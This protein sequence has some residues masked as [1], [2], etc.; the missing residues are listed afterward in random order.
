MTITDVEAIPV[1]LPTHK[2]VRFANG[3]VH[4]AEHVLVR[5]QTEDGLEGV[6]E[7]SPRLMTYGDT[8]Q[9]VV[10]LIRDA[11]APMWIGEDERFIAARHAQLEH[12]VGN[13]PARAALDVALWDLLGKRAGLPVALLYGGARHRVAV[14]H[15]L[16]LGAPQE[17]AQE[18]S[19]V[20]SSLGVRAF[21]VKV[22]QTPQ[23]DV[24]RTLAVREAVGR[25]AVLYLDAN[26]GW[27]PH[28]RTPGAR[29]ARARGRVD[30][31][32]GGAYPR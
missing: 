22:G 8:A 7:A 31:L 23:L 12:L 4:H 29:R 6:A 20:A 25:D 21:K 19:D 18:A 5:V 26:H 13:R 11:I 9:A 24:Q 30:R 3:E 14:A 28:G 2:P 10:A 27:S 15:L 32:G 1:R 17:M 16:G